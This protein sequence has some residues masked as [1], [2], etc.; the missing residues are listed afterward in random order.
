[1]IK[2]LQN[3]FRAFHKVNSNKFNVINIKKRFIVVKIK[4]VTIN[5]LTK[6]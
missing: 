1:M 2:Y 4:I 5:K 3:M 6:K